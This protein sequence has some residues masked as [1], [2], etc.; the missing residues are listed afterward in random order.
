MVSDPV[1][2]GWDPAPS[3]VDG[4]GI[5]CAYPD[6]GVT[7]RKAPLP[8]GVGRAPLLQAGGKGVDR[9]CALPARL[10]GTAMLRLDWSVAV[11]L[12]GIGGNE[13]IEPGMAPPKF[14]TEPGMAPA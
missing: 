1:A 12:T 11:L 13:C 4:I 7:L 2:K 9:M 8:G 14:E 3:I 6:P 5:G 10:L